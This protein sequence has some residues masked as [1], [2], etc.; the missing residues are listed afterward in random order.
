MF[1]SRKADKMFRERERERESC[2]KF[3]AVEDLSTKW[4]FNGEGCVCTHEKKYAREVD[5]NFAHVVP[6][7]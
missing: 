5:G 2:S 3:S 6:R 7:Q 4:F 1:H